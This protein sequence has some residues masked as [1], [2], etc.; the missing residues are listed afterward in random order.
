MASKLK[1]QV[2]GIGALPVGE[3]PLSIPLPLVSVLC[4]GTCHPLCRLTKYF[5]VGTALGPPQLWEWWQSVLVSLRHCF[6]Q[7]WSTEVRSQDCHGHASRHPMG[8]KEEVQTL[9]QPSPQ[10]MCPQSSQLLRPDQTYP[11]C[12]STHVHLDVP[13]VLSLQSSQ[14]RP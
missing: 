12:R 5:V 14:Q 4:C 9:A 7:N 8:A 1:F 10:C 13:Q 3:E 11:S 6:H 2:G